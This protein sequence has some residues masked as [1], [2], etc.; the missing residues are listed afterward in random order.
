MEHM[1]LVLTPV[2]RTQGLLERVKKNLSMK[3]RPS[4]SGSIS[5]R[6][7]KRSERK[8]AREGAEIP[9]MREKELRQAVLSEQVLQSGKDGAEG[10]TGKLSLCC[11]GRSQG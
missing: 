11:L 4:K 5:I 6:W 10:P 8:F 3:I 1:T 2:P 9:T 7:R